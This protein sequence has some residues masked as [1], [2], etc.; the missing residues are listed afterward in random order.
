MTGKPKSKEQ[1][2]KMPREL[3]QSSAWRSLGIH[4]RRFLDY[5][6]L[7]Q[8]RFAGRQNGNLTAPHRQLVKFGIG[9]RFIAQTIQG[10][11]SRGLIRCAR[12]DAYSPNTYALTW[13]SCRG[14]SPTNDWRRYGG[15][16]PVLHEGA[17]RAGG[18]T[19]VKRCSTS[20]SRR[21]STRA[22][23]PESQVVEF[24]RASGPVLHEGAAIYRSSYQG[25]L[26]IS[27]ES[28][29]RAPTLQDAADTSEIRNAKS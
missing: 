10:L 26:G 5:L 8:M 2:V 12:H 17:A 3:L 14:A 28:D 25:G 20:A 13:L 16:I 6:M 9:G 7:E 11:E 18:R 1:F 23:N 21:C 15:P 19:D 24:Q 29:D 27:V 4:D 22:Q